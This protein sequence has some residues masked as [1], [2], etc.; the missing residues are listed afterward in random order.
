MPGEMS[1]S[2][3]LACAIIAVLATFLCTPL[4]TLSSADALSVAV[5]RP[6]GADIVA[7]M[8]NISGNSTG[9]EGVQ[10][11]IDSGAWWNG[12]GV[13]KW[14]YLWN[15]TSVPNGIHSVQARAYNGSAYA[16]SSVVQFTVN[17]TPH[18]SLEITLDLSPEEVFSGEDFVASGMASYDNGVRVSSG[19]VQVAF[20]NTSDNVTTDSRGYYS[21]QFPA[22]MSPGRTAVRASIASS[23]LSGSALA[24]IDVVFRAP[25]DLSVSAENITFNPSEPSGGDEVTIGAIVSN[26]GGSN[27]SGTV[28]FSTQGHDPQD[29]HVNVSAG[30]SWPA[31]VKW[32][33]PSG[34]HTIQVSLLD[35]LPYDSNPSNDNATR[36]LRVL[37]SPDLAVAA[38]LFSNSRP[39]AGMTITIQARVSNTG[40]KEASGSV[41]IY[42]GRPPAGAKIGTQRLL[43]PANTTRTVLLDWN[44]TAGAHNITAVV[45]DVLPADPDMSDNVLTRQLD[46]AKKPSPPSNPAPGPG[47]AALAAAMLLAFFLLPGRAGGR[48]RRLKRA[49]S[50]RN[51]F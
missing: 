3:G 36:E 31:S 48:H 45:G 30:G 14:H 21:S 4:F 27:A 25:P 13:P 10:I 26:P 32:R 43:V 44:A 41:T 23:G 51:I 38:I 9:A 49:W 16:A 19:T 12:S 20:A 28:R 29:I 15:S 22:P 7:G 2:T 50:R 34:R 6:L 24:Y 35:V 46:V 42:D 18:S 11:S 5:E 8:V 39:T 47:V 1:A 33:L 37:A 17:N 40:E